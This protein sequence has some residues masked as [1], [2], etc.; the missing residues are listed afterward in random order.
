MRA[1]EFITENIHFKID[2]NYEKFYGDDDYVEYSKLVNVNVKKLDHLW[3]K[4]YSMY[5]GKG[6]EGQIKDR[7][8]RF[9]DFLNNNPSHI[10]AP[11]VSISNYGVTFGN[12]RHR[13]AWFRDHGYDVIPVSMDKESIRYAKQLG[14]LE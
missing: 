10:N 5:I 8:Q 12:G 6:G 7:Y 14:I 4:D 2:P 3:K 11:H 1:V 13:F 9:G